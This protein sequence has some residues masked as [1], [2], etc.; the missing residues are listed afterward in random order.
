MKK[1]ILVLILFLGLAFGVFGQSSDPIDLVVLL[2]TSAGMS[3]YYRET[4]DYLIGPFLREFL[5]LG[6]TFHLIS[7]AGS[8]RL[9]ITRRIEDVGDVETI[10]ARLLL[11]YPLYPQSNIDEALGFAER[12]TSSLP[13][14]RSR[15]L[16]FLTDGSAPNTQ[17]MA[18]QA[19]ERLR[20]QRTEFHYIQI[21]VAG[22]GPSSGR[23]GGQA[24]PSQIAAP[25][26]AAPQAAAPSQQE[27]ARP[28][29][30]TVGQQAAPTQPPPQ[31][32]GRPAGPSGSASARE[33]P[34]PLLVALGLLALLI[35]GLI[36]FFASRRL[37]STP[38][39]AMAK[40]ALPAEKREP[41]T[42]KSQASQARPPL[43]QRPPDRKPLPK[44]K[45]YDDTFYGDGGPLMLNL[46]VVDQN[47]A[48]GKRN[49][50]NVKAGTTLSVGGGKSDF[51]IFL[52]PIPPS[53]ASVHYDGRNCTFTPVKPQYFPDIGSQSVSNCLG[54]TI[55]VVSDKNYELHL[56]VERY[57]DPLQVL[58]RLLN[59]ISA[60]GPSLPLKKK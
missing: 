45:P 3:S 1:P 39:K 21:P 20:G 16:I 25:Q 59:S 6:D 49:V 22:G 52:V 33:L 11:M 53:I 9:E 47:T 34:V 12:Y 31:A 35:L 19:G 46:F 60:P 37:H 51:L 43:E 32:A 17:N 54:K 13:G 48:I 10:I 24:A 27:T 8:P 55:R 29:G 41:Q 18:N 38:N 2:D 50:H 7:F 23:P 15:K 4:S 56:R 36:I 26:V 40:A 44:D 57:E 14:D 28:P 58:N 30:Q 5:R 42:Q